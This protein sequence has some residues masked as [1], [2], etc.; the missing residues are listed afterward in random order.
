[1]VAIEH[2]LSTFLVFSLAKSRGAL[3]LP[4]FILEDLEGASVP[5]T[6]GHE[7]RFEQDW[8]ELVLRAHDH[9]EDGNEHCKCTASH[10]HKQERLRL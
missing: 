10:A 9:I 8:I 5:L 2:A 6:S 7:V 1:M 3:D 4:L